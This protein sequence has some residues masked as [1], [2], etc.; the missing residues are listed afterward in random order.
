M[1]NRKEW[2]LVL[3]PLAVTWLAD[4]ISKYYALK[5][6]TTYIKG[7]LV[8]S[9]HYNHGA[10][11]GLFSDLPSVLRIVSL[12]TAGA[13]LVCTFGIIQYLLPIK[14]L[15]LRAGTSFLL[16]G[17]LGNVTDRIVYGYI[18]DF[19]IVGTSKIS[20]AAFN[21]AD[22]L[23]WVG[24]AMIVFALVKEGNVLWPEM[25]MRK[26]AW[27]NP[28]FQLKY[29]TMLVFVV[30]GLTL[31]SGVFSYTYLRVSINEIVG[32]NSP[33]LPKF[34]KPFL[35]TYTSITLGFCAVVFLVGKLISHKIAGPVY[36][37][38]R[39][40]NELLNGKDRKLKLRK[41]DE[42]KNLEDVAE[43][44]RVIWSSNGHDK[45]ESMLPFDPD[46]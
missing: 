16:G 11:L 24:Y 41:G 37:L 23:Q 39:Y 15:V 33:I 17:I 31:I 3:L 43:K 32:D 19:I 34:L 30:M 35:V 46:L 45:S 2:F 44:I 4:Q 26:T 10:M 18:I 36:A 29:S 22:A 27:V 7:I 6:T 14:S 25:N 42:F 9:L 13:F 12:A 40:V 28:S 1:L 8:L 38:E 20:T 21:V 5:L